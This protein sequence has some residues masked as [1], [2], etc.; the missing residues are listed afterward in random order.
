MKNP[1]DFYHKGGTWPKEAGV[2][3]I[4]NSATARCKNLWLLCCWFSLPPIC[5][6]FR[7]CDCD[8]QKLL[9]LICVP[10]WP[11]GLAVAGAPSTGI[12]PGRLIATARTVGRFCD[13]SE[14]FLDFFIAQSHKVRSGWTLLW[15]MC[16][17]KRSLQGALWANS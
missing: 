16:R 5:T 3:R 4:P 9:D 2:N 11:C 15:Q 1:T 14:D 12:Q 6:H 10:P 7:Y 13:E 8:G 17:K